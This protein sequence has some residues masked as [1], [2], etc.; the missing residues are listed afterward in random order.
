MGKKVINRGISA[1]DVSSPIVIDE[2]SNFEFG[3]VDK[4]LE[5]IFVIVFVAPLIVL[6][7]R[8]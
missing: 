3:K 4:A 1:N 7:A 5:G 2:L 6:F 8:T